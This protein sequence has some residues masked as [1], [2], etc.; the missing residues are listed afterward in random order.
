MKYKVGDRVRL[1]KDITED[2]YYNAIYFLPEMNIYKNQVELTKTVKLLDF[3]V[4]LC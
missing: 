3:L 1:R 2:R 4:L